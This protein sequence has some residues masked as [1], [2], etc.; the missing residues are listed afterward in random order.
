MRGWLACVLLSAS[1]TAARADDPWDEDVGAEAKADADALREEGD[2]LFARE[3]YQDALDLYGE[4][5]KS[6][7]HPE[8]RLLMV[9]ALIALERRDDAR[10]Q[11]DLALRYDGAPFDAGT[12]AEARNY[13]RLL[14]PAPET[15]DEAPP[16]DEVER[17]VDLPEDAAEDRRWPTWAPWVVGGSGLGVVVLGVMLDVKASRDLDAFHRMVA[18]ECPDACLSE[19]IDRSAADLAVAEN[20]FAIGMI[21]VGAVATLAGVA[22]VVLDPD[23]IALAGRF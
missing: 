4:A 16:P 6:W 17:P 19:T 7:D 20:R 8:I 14:A 9:R 21:V 13:E 11:L 15:P 3:R 10:E 22:G 2:A 1:V 5:V 12:Y 23:G 18:A